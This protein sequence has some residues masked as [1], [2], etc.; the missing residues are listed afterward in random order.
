MTERSSQ[1][2]EVVHGQVGGLYDRAAMPPASMNP[3]R[4]I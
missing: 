2:L 3:E 1:P 4:E